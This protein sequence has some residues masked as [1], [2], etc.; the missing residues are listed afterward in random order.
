MNENKQA[1]KHIWKA[2]GLS[3]GDFG[4]VLARKAKNGDKFSSAGR[5]GLRGFSTVIV[6]I[7]WFGILGGACLKKGGNAL[8]AMD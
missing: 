3:K 8:L 7:L 2:R 5:A 1:N 4:R 6:K